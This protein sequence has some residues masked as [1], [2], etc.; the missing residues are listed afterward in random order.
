MH[1]DCS[2]LILYSKRVTKVLLLVFFYVSVSLGHFNKRHVDF[3]TSS[4]YH[5][6]R[7]MPLQSIDI[8]L[9]F[10]VIHC[11]EE[12]TIWTRKSTFNKTKWCRLLY[13][14]GS[15]MQWSSNKSGR[16]P[17]GHYTS[18]V[19]N[20]VIFS[21]GPWIRCE[22]WQFYGMNVSNKKSTQIHFNPHNFLI[23]Q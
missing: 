18:H 8:S 20:S 11:N 15:V 16:F 19:I 23:K 10:S 21:H 17:F 14:I 2:D 13:R 6:H 1:I 3:F 4:H 22:M 12:K 7:Q 5:Y 9:I